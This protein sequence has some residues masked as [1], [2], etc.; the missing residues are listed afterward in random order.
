ME[1]VSDSSPVGVPG[2]ATAKQPKWLRLILLSVLAYEGLG[3]LTGGA[4][5]TV[6]PDGRLMDMSVEIMHGSFRD[7]LIP[8]IILFLLGILTSVAFFAV[9]RRNR[10]D[11]LLASL[12]MGGL[13][14]WFWVEIAILLDLHWL[15]AMW[16]LPVVAGALAT[17][18]LFTAKGRLIGA[19]ICGMASA[20]LYAVINVIVPLQWPEYNSATQTVSE[21]SAVG[22]PTRF[23]WIV[24][25]APYTFLSIAFAIGMRKA[26][27]DNWKLHLAGSLLI[28]YGFLGVLWP[29]APMHLRETLA[30]GGGTF[31]DTM[32]LT[33]GAVTEVI[34][35]IALGIS[36]AALGKGFRVFSITTF[37]LLMLFGVLTFLEAPNVS[38]NLPTPFI[39]L[40]ER[41]NIGLFLLWV[42][43]L[44]VILLNKVNEPSAA[45]GPADNLNHRSY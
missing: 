35:L 42:C 27:A 14:I 11:W 31:T 25:S 10:L 1:N 15:H 29:L 38:R 16:G 36:A 24:L 33:L 7:F 17:L 3:C 41:I 19:L 30:S 28:V 20:V 21:L 5:L 23:L 34:Y 6:A 22:A 32:H 2:P 26:A 43:V 4:L 9:L 8:G 44:S 45:A 18:S 39:G 37:I 40:L 12:S 13:L